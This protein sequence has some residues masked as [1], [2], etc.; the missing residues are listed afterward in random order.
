MIIDEE[1]NSIFIVEKLNNLK[2][3]LNKD[4]VNLKSV[5]DDIKQIENYDNT[6]NYEYLN[7]LL[8]P[9]NKKGVKIPSNKPIPSCS[10]QMHN[11]FSFYPNG[12]GHDL[13]YFNPWFLASE[14]IY[15][16]EIPFEN[17]IYHVDSGASMYFA[18]IVIDADTS[19]SDPFNWY[20]PSG[21]ANQVIPDVYAKYRLVS[22][23]MTLRY[24]GQLDEACGVVG[25]AIV[26]NKSP[27]LGCR[28]HRD[29]QQ[30]NWGGTR[31]GCLSSI[32]YE[33]IRDS[34]YSTEHSIL[35]GL[36]MLYFPLDNNFNEFRDVCDGTGITI[37]RVTLTD[38]SNNFFAFKI[39]KRFLNTGFG[40][41]CYTQSAPITQQKI[42]KVDYYLNFECLPKASFMNY[43]P[44][45]IN[46]VYISPELRKKFIEEVQGKALQKINIY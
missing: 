41:A 5:Q 20:Y 33:S 30:P 7:S 1:N 42:F 45:S 11:S 6:A 39:P 34:Y 18:N 31:D 38:G 17:S 32:N 4:K 8:D 10:F 43:I 25:G 13:F 26:Y 9:I 24:T 29:Q 15:E 19:V 21:S 28:F 40:W 12:S 22:A 35:E 2:N 16:A 3:E 36:K 14:K 37:E 27:N 44:C 23:C 46:V